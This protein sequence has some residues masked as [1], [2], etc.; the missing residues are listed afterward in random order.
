MCSNA[1]LLHIS[2][3]PCILAAMLICN[4]LPFQ[5]T[6]DEKL[7]II[8]LPIIRDAAR[9]LLNLLWRYRVCDLLLVLSGPTSNNKKNDN[10]IMITVLSISSSKTHITYVNQFKTCHFIV[11]SFFCLSFFSFLSRDDFLVWNCYY[12]FTCLF[13]MFLFVKRFELQLKKLN[14]KKIMSQHLKQVTARR[15]FCYVFFYHVRHFRGI[16]QGNF[17]VTM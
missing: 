11:C 15:L 8:V 7:A 2:R 1:R 3:A 13:I 12:Y 4:K 5:K 14:N 16:G 17:C 6:E 9:G 10:K